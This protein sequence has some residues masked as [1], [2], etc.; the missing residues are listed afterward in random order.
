MKLM[1]D[2]NI[3]LDLLFKRNDF[4]NISTL[5]RSLDESGDEACISAS[6]VTD[7]FYIIRKLTHDTQKTYELLEYV[8]EIVSILPVTPT[9]I[10][11]AFQNK[12]KDFEDCV[13]Y[14]VAQ[15][16]NISAIISNNK[17]DFEDSTIQIYT[18]KDYLDTM[19]S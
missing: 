14:T 11:C 16:N 5:F 12:W 4:S 1:I 2:T 15:K 8:L 3:I 6:S 17:K 10:V 7:L 18:A 19:R 9:D 13:L